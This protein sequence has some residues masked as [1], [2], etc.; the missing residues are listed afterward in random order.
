MLFY[1][2]HARSWKTTLACRVYNDKS[3]V[4]HFD[5][6]A[7]CTVDQEHNNKKSLQKIFDQVIGLKER[8]DEDDIDDDV[9]DKLRKELF[10]K[11]YPIVLD[12]MQDT[13]TWH[14]LTDHYVSFH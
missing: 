3:V 14:K 8:F 6:R 10:G 12:D 1:S 4:C 11:R 9:A 13:A 7:W 5:I 2:R